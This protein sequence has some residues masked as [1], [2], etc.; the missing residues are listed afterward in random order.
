MPR[1]IRAA[2]CPGGGAAPVIE[3]LFLADPAPDEV[4]LRIE[5]AGVC[6]TDL[7]VSRWT[8]CPRVLGHEGAGTVVETGSAVRNLR[9]G[10]KVLA[11]F[12]SCGACPNCADHRPAYCLSGPEL[13]FEGR[14]SVPE[15][16]VTRPDGSAIAAGFFGQSSFATHALASERNCVT[17]PEDTPLALAAPMGCSIQTGAGAVFSQIGASAQRPLLV[18]GAGAVGLAAVMAGR[19]LGCAPILMVEPRHDRR[20]LAHELGASLAIDAADSDW[21]AQVRERTGG[22]AS[23]AL[24]TAG[25]QSTFE[26]GL[27]AL[28]PGGTLGVVTLPAAFGE[29]VRHPGGMDFLAK[30]IVGVVEGDSDPARLLPRLINHLKAGELPIDRIVTHYRFADIARAFS[31]AA[32]RTAIKPVLTFVEEH[33]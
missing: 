19:I 25:L 31:D 27:A 18:I 20:A 29:P 33:V 14:R 26:G 30:S 6:H 28:R 15:P 4:V 8:P 21:P 32:T 22:G 9:P 16:A 17:V 3:D 23:A 7:E 10:D 2:V 1:R 13:N 24:D 11:T 5:A 12:A